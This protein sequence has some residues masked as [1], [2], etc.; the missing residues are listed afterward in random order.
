MDTT[1]DTLNTKEEKILK[2]DAIT[3]QTT[4]VNMEELKQMTA[5]LTNAN[6]ISYNSIEAYDPYESV[7]SR[8][9]YGTSS[10][11]SVIYHKIYDTSSFP[12]R[13]TCRIYCSGGIGSGFLVGPNLLLTAAHCVINPKNN[14]IFTGWVCD[15]GYNYGA[16]EGNSCGWSQIYYSS[17]WISN[18]S[19]EYDW[20]LCVLEENLGS[21]LGY[22]G[23][24]AY[25]TNSELNNVSVRA[26]GYPEFDN[27]YQYYTE[28]TTSN[29][30]TNYF[31]C[32]AQ[33]VDGMSGGPIVRTSDNYAIGLVK[34]VYELNSSNTYAVRITQ[35]IIDLIRSLRT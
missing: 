32:S 12:N 7:L 23:C 35:S 26:F 16:Y 14:S 4:E 19:N 34:G 2:Y 33:V 11:T 29:A 21:N 20:C 15:P 3:N 18:H 22:F 5:L 28:G 1:N 24:Q 6:D 8:D 17:E 30:H 9:N 13:V 10:A 27:Q 25:G 31:N